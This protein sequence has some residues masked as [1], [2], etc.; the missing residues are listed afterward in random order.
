MEHIIDITPEMEAVYKKLFENDNKFNQKEYED[1]LHN[2][3]NDKPPDG[4]HVYL[5]MTPR[6]YEE[7]GFERLPMMITSKHLYSTLMANGNLTST[8]FDTVH[9]HDLGENILKQIP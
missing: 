7:F 9:Y 6:I 5:G 3:A 2:I 4:S 1:I 8:A